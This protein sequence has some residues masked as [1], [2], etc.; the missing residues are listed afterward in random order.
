MLTGERIQRSPGSIQRKEQRKSSASRHINGGIVSEFNFHRYSG[1]VLLSPN[2]LS[3]SSFL[4]ILLSHCYLLV[5]CWLRV[6]NRGWRSWKS[7]TRS[8]SPYAE[9]SLPCIIKLSDIVLNS[10]YF[11][12]GGNIIHSCIHSIMLCLFIEFNLVHVNGR[13][14][15]K[16]CRLDFFS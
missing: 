7:W 14:G 15:L 12:F 8:R 13:P 5:S 11:F 1:L 4:L 9:I 3:L 2:L 10:I 6:K 16:S